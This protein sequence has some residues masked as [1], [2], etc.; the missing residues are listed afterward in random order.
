[1]ILLALN[2]HSRWTRER[3]EA[4]KRRKAAAKAAA[5]S[6]SSSS[7]STGSGAAFAKY[8]IPARDAGTQTQNSSNSPAGEFSESSGQVGEVY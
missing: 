2:T 4:E 1:M 7:T 6:S 8:T 5:A 3:E